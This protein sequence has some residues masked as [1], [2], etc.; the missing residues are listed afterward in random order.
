MDNNT[1]VVSTK[2]GFAQ[3]CKSSVITGFG[4]GGSLG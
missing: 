2:R 4:H 1:S 3:T